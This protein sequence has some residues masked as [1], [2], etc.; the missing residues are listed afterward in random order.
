MGRHNSADCGGFNPDLPLC[1]SAPQ[2]EYDYGGAYWGFNDAAGPVYA[3]WVR[4]RGHELGVVYIRARSKAQA[5]RFS[6]QQD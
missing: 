1:V 6:A 4:A 2:G 3:V 5:K